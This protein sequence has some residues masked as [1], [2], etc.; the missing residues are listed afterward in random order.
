MGEGA[1]DLYIKAICGLLIQTYEVQD[2]IDTILGESDQTSKF[3]SSI[4]LRNSGTSNIS[5]DSTNKYYNVNITKHGSE[6]FIPVNSADGLDDVIIEFDGYLTGSDS[7]IGLCFYKEGSNWCRLGTKTSAM[8]YGEN[9]N[10]TYAENNITGTSAP[11]N[12]WLHYKFTITNGTI[13]RQVYNGETLI[14]EETRTYAGFFTSNTKYGF[15][16]LWGTNWHQYI[17]NIKI[18]PL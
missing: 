14:Y 5:Y 7:L 11:A 6:S 1:G 2:C 8:E 13:H 4:G 9:I 10:G 16:A 17:K 3:G 15:T 18:K 12:T